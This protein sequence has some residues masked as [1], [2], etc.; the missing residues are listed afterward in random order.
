MFLRGNK[1]LTDETL[2]EPSLT[3]KY[4]KEYKN[5]AVVRVAPRKRVCPLMS[6]GQVAAAHPN[7]VSHCIWYPFTRFFEGDSGDTKG[8]M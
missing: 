1:P 3:R 7:D 5:N 8:M 4:K 6:R 2:R